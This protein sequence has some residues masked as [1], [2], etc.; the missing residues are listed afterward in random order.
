MAGRSTVTRR[1]REARRPSFPAPVKAERT[2][3]PDRA[4]RT[5]VNPFGPSMPDASR[6]GLPGAPFPQARSSRSLVWRALT[7]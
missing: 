6:Q 7:S 1:G 2:R 4:P 5:A 3:P